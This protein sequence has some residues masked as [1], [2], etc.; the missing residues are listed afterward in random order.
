M[1]SADAL[2]GG[3][4]AEMHV[5]RLLHECTRVQVVHL[6]HERSGTRLFIHIVHVQQVYSRA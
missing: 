3:D 1:V 2:N 4:V 5:E 6:I